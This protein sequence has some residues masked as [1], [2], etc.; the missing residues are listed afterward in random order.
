MNVLVTGAGGFLGGHLVDQLLEKNVEVRVLSRRDLPDLRAK[1]VEVAHADL[2]DFYNVMAACRGID[3]VYHVAAK[4]G[5]WGDWESFHQPNTIGT[6]HVIDACK[7]V[8]VKRLV[9]TSSPS[10]VFDGHSHLEADES[11]KYPES[12][13]CHYPHTKALA[14]HEVLTANSEKL[15]TC[16]LRP[17][18][19]WGPRDNHLIPRLLKRYDLNRL[20]RVGDGKNVISMSYVENAAAAHIQAEEEL[21][22]SGKNAGK[23]YFINDPDPVNLW[24]WVDQ[25]LEATGRPKLNK[26]LSFKAAHMAG[27]VCET[28]YKMLGKQ[29]EPPMTR[30]VAQQLSLSHTYSIQRAIDDFGYRPIVGPQ[31]AYNRLLEWLYN[32]GYMKENAKP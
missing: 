8:G 3:V 25:L 14:E 13:L 7:R 20:R 27:Q 18:L 9:Y 16:S 24:S 31:E 12:Y 10:V 4:P 6:R 11:L 5:V 21:R 22:T 17:H 19:I 23:A 32:E 26:K 30:F 2:T 28:L 15:K 29:D 1:G